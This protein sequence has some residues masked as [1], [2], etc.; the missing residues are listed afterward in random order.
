MTWESKKNG[1]YLWEYSSITVKM[2]DK[3]ESY[4]VLKK[5]SDE[6]VLLLNM[7]TGGCFLC[8]GINEY[9]GI[10]DVHVNTSLL[11]SVCDEVVLSWDDI[12]LVDFKEI[13]KNLCA[14]T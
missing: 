8:R 11:V 4:F 9:L 14:D 2:N 10:D 6:E 13:E 3:V 12:S 1:S 5:Y 7:R